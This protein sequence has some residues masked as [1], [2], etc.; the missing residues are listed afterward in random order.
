[1]N[2]V[3][4]SPG[5]PA[6]MPLFVRGLAQVGARVLGVGDQPREAL[7]EECQK[8][9]TAYGR[10]DLNDEES[11]LRAI[12]EQ[13]RGQTIDRVECLWEPG[14][15]MAA[16]L[17]ER[18]GVP[19]MT[20]LE[21]V[22][23]RDKEHMK[24]VLDRAGIR[25]PKHA[26]ARTEAEVRAAAERIGYP[27]IVKPIAGAGSKDTYKLDQA[28]E[29]A[30]ALQAIK[31]VPEVSVE[32]YIDGEEF[33]YDTVCADGRICYF[34]L[35]WYRPKP[36]YMA[37]IPW[38]SPQSICFRDTEAPDIVMGRVLGERVL[39]ALGFR[40]GFTHMEWFRTPQGEA[41]FGE[42]A[43]R[44][45]GARLVHAMNY[46]SDIDLFAGWAE[47]TCYGRFSQRNE[48]LYNTGMVFKRAEGQGRIQ[49][50]EGLAS[51]LARYGEHIAHI[52]LTP[53]GQPRRDPRTVLVGDGWVIVRHPDL[54]FTI[55]MADRIGTDLRLYAS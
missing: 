32:E 33:T 8:H 25:T 1:M 29:L 13:I 26:R 15:L 39:H 50:I 36:M 10:A 3:F 9:L 45:P 21:T 47:A 46:G 7:P 23:F 38:I 14:M 48:K 41:V 43:A 31:H 44:P 19:G 53:I 40:T 4:L 30:P 34:N 18:L 17:R 20:A 6:E 51:L 54:A 2:V 52:E 27:L 5:F 16:R 22:P 28:S 37:R 42:I 55:E 49:R 24:Q 11:V 12:R 35:S